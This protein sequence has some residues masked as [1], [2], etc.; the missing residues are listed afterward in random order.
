MKLYELT[1]QFK[2]LEKMEGVDPIPL[3]DTIDSIK[4]DIAEKGKGVASY[5]QNLDIDIAAIDDAI[6]RMTA[7]KKALKADSD[8][9]KEY[10]LR[11]MQEC[12]ISEISCPE[13]KITI[14][15]PSKVVQI[16]DEKAITSD[17]I[18]IVPEFARPDKVAIKK[19]LKAGESVE[20]AELVDGK[21]SLI[22][23]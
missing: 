22:I 6:A 1:D 14:R 12:G 23:K 5:F 21:T 10:L 9:L 4:G 19:A 11:N 7:R 16:N 15:K 8:Y 13:F 17:F 18:T 20:G 2:Q 3:V